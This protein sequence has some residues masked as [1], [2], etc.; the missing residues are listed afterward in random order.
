MHLAGSAA[1]APYR[2]NID[3]PAAFFADHPGQKR[4]RQIK[5][6]VQIDPHHPAPILVCDILKQ[7]LLRDPRVIDQHIHRAALRLH[8][9]GKFLRLLRVGQIR[10]QR[11]RLRPLFAQSARQPLRLFQMAITAAEHLVPRRREL[12]RHRLANPA[13]S[14][15]YDRRR[16]QSFSPLSCLG[17][18]LQ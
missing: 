13:G 14:A 4:P 2:G 9:P 11:L 17:I 8:H 5:N 7:L 18:R 16:F 10:L 6:A 15:C 1:N 3:N 12:P